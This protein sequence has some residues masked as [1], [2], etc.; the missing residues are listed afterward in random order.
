MPIFQPWKLWLCK[1]IKRSMIEVC[2]LVS[3]P[4][5]RLQISLGQSFVQDDSSLGCDNNH[6]NNRDKI[7]KFFFVSSASKMLS[8]F[9]GQTLRT[10][11]STR[12]MPRLSLKRSACSILCF[13]LLLKAIYFSFAFCILSYL[14]K[15]QSSVARLRF[16][17]L[18]HLKKSG[19]F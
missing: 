13:E 12:L 7:V 19:N 4:V 1:N 15:I 10:P 6:H 3:D 16:D 14:K 18:K 17:Q 5:A 9:W 8:R 2:S 11:W